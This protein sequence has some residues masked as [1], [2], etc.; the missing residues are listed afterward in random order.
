[1][2]LVRPHSHI[3]FFSMAPSWKCSGS[4]DWD[5]HANGAE[6]RRER[7]KF[8]SLIDYKLADLQQ[9]MGKH[10]VSTDHLVQSMI[11]LQW[12]VAQQQMFQTSVLDRLYVAV[13][14]VKEASSKNARYVEVPRFVRFPRSLKFQL[15]QH[16]WL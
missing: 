8:A 14:D 2:A 15:Q 5:A 13:V 7:R 4:E 11:H 12:T 6:K 16:V 9:D 10:S 3:I 1:M